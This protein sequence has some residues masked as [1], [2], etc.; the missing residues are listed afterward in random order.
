LNTYRHYHTATALP[1]GNVLVSGGEDAVTANKNDELY[2]FTLKRMV[3]TGRPNSVRRGHTATLLRTGKVLITGGAI[4]NSVVT[5]T[6]ELYDP[7]TGTWTPV[8][9]MSAA[10][11]W[12]SATLLNDGKVLVVGTVYSNPTNKVELYDPMT[13]TWETVGSIHIEHQGH[14][15]TLL[16]SGKV[17]IA[18]GYRLTRAELYDPETRSWSPT[19]SMT[20]PRHDH[21][22]TLLPSGQVLVVGGLEDNSFPPK[23]L[24][25]AELYDPITGTWTPTTGNM[26]FAR[27]E[28]TATLQLDNFVLVT[29]G[30]D[31]DNVVAFRAETYDLRTGQWQRALP[32]KVGISFTATPLPF[33]KVLLIGY[34][35][36]AEY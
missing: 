6:A 5:N 4:A 2:D 13:D 25:S 9:S 29:G 22:A 36:A 23:R 28:H 26:S 20:T 24:S 3:E 11:V 27:S 7:D 16:P 10:R 14:T 8:A 31:S 19:G 35:A 34:S 17:L 32:P 15:A 21:T 33:G 30:I 18:G 1:S 12:H